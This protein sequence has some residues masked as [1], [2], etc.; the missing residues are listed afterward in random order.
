MVKI[1]VTGANGQLGNCFKD[2][3]HKYPSLDITFVS[4]NELD[5][6]NKQAVI[7]YFKENK[8][9]FV[10]NTAAY[11]A[12]DLAE[13]HIKD[14]RLVNA[15]AVHYLAEQTKLCNILDILT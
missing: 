4:R 15:T 13:S 7:T 6:T 2:V 11:T 12:V 5:I 10:I 1:L 9:Q 3:A 14:A 8:F